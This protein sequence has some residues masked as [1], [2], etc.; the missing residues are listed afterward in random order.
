MIWIALAALIVS[1]AGI[2]LGLRANAISQAAKDAAKISANEARK[3]RLDNLAPSISIS[4]PEPQH[5][6]WMINSTFDTRHFTHPVPVM[7][8]TEFH[9]PADAPVRVLVGAIV[10]V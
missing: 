7:P 3:S 8:S 10:I 9:L 1:V 5:T 6:R 2:G 4:R